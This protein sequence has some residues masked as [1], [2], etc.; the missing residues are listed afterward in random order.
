MIQENIS[1]VEQIKADHDSALRELSNN[2]NAAITDFQ[3]K[4]AEDLHAKL[5]A[6]ETIRASIES[7]QT[8]TNK[9][10]DEQLQQLSEESERLISDF[11]MELASQQTA[12]SEKLQHT[13]QAIN[14]YQADAEQKYNEF[15]H[16]LE[17]TNVDQIFKEVQDLKQ[18]FQTKFMIMMGGIGITLVVALLGLFL[19]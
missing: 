17:T 16:R 5:A 1:S 13:E 14:G 4:S 9:K 2:N 7:Y 6:I 10:T 19:K 11:K 8:E 12:F 18:S 15:I 3:K